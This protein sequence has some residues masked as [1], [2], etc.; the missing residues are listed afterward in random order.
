MRLQQSSSRLARRWGHDLLGFCKSLQDELEPSEESEPPAVATGVRIVDEIP[1]LISITGQAIEGRIYEIPQGPVEIL[2]SPDEALQQVREALGQ[3]H[4]WGAV[5]AGLGALTGVLGGGGQEL[6]EQTPVAVT[7]GNCLTAYAAFQDVLNVSEELGISLAQETVAVIGIPGSVATAVARLLSPHVGKLLLVGRVDS[8]RLR[9]ISQELAAESCTDLPFAIQQSRLLVTA[10][11][12]GHCLDPRTLASGSI[13]WDVAVPADVQMDH[14]HRDDVLVLSSGLSVLPR[15]VERQGDFLWLSR[16]IIPSCLG[17]TLLLA[18]ENRAESLSIGRQLDLD[19][20]QEIGRIARRHGFTFSPWL[21]QGQTVSETQRTKLRKLWSGSTVSAKTSFKRSAAQFGRYVNP[22]LAELL[23]EGDL[24]RTYVRGEGCRLWDSEGREYLDF[25]AGYGSVN[26]G[27][28]EPGISAAIQ[29]ALQSQAV[30]FTPS[31]VNPYAAELAEQLAT[32][33]PAGLDLVTF[34]N[35][36][37]EAVEAALKLARAATHRPRL[38]SWSR[39]YHGKTL[40][41]LSVTGYAPYREP[42]LPLLPGSQP[43]PHGD[44]ERLHR[45]LSQRDV[46][47][48]IIEPVAAE[49]GMHPLAEGVLSRIRQICTATGTLLIADEVQTGLCRTGTLFAV[50]AEQVTPD[51]LCLAKSLGGGHLPLG[52]MLCRRDHWMTAYGT[53][54]SCLRHTSTFAGG[55][56]A[57]A[58]GLAS[59]KL[60]RNPKILQNVQQRS[61]Q[62]QAG[63]QPLIDRS[64]LIQELRG[65][66]LLLGLE[67]APLPDVII[68][69]WIAEAGIQPLVIPD[70]LQ[71]VKDLPAFYVMQSLLRKHHIVTQI[72]RSQPNVLRIEPPLIVTAAEVDQFLAALDQACAELEMTNQ[73]FQ[74]CVTKSVRGELQG[75]R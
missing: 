73:L 59:L 37:A 39:G 68:D 70:Y 5:I 57:C 56:L 3:A 31:A 32:L 1:K 45:E 16:G 23:Q 22:V 41:A 58:A 65:R 33:A 46:A 11:S 60:A 20:I 48:F 66:G 10:T 14:L 21:S 62:L 15:G 53:L 43:I 8:P 12:A 35:S 74:N 71:R 51:I 24:L 36:G 64:P 69:H 72:C 4:E 55:S 50:E 9:R 34:V 26:W 13:V 18:W 47:A 40:G 6:A 38:L 25:V 28:N 61:S 54:D 75:H 49:G 42:F 7:T 63:I 17:E 67:F 19:R 29:T 30:G 52:A 27:H 2:D 44:L